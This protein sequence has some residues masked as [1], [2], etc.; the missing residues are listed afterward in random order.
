MPYLL[1]HFA[2]SIA[3]ITGV[4]VTLSLRLA[5][6]RW[7]IR[8]PMFRPKNLSSAVAVSTSPESSRS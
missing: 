2:V 3:A 5:G 4:L 7:R 6:I 1:E 8:L